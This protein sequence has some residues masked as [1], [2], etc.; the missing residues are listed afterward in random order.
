MKNVKMYSKVKYCAVNK[1]SNLYTANGTYNP[2]KLPKRGQIIHK[3]LL[4]L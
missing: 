2:C 3:Y 1:E 4:L